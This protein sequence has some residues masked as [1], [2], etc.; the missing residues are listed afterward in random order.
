V[1]KGSTQIE[2]VDNE[3]TF[4]P[5]VR[6]CLYSPAPSHGYPFELRVVSNECKDY[7][8]QWKL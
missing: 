2:G 3:E 4:S 1:A 6:I 8:P 5:I 7:F